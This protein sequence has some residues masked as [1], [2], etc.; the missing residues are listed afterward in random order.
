MLVRRRVVNNLKQK[1]LNGTLNKQSYASYL[2][3]IK[4]ANAYR[5]KEQIKLLIEGE[6]LND[7]PTLFTRNRT[8]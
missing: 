4:H 3:H 1:I 7:M 8:N 6:Y 5:L 2:G